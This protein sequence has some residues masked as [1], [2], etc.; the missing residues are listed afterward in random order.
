MNAERLDTGTEAPL[1]LLLASGSEVHLAGAGVVR[2]T[3]RDAALLAWLA[4]EGPT[5]R[6]RLAQLLWPQS[7]GESAGNALRQRL[8]HLKKQFGVGLVTGRATL[9][10][11][12]RVA[13]DLDAASGVLGEASH[14]LTGELAEWVDRRRLQRSLGARQKLIERL[15]AAEQEGDY[16]K[17][18]LAANEALT[19]DPMS[20]EAHQ[21]VI[22]LYYLAGDRPLALLAFDRCERVLKTEFGFAP[23]AKT[24]ELLNAI[25]QSR[26]LALTG[27]MRGGGLPAA[28]LRPPR[29][30]GRADEW[31]GLADGWGAGRSAIIVGEGGM[32]K[33]RLVRDFAL[34]RKDALIVD[35]RPGDSR[36]PHAL[37]SR[38]L[39]ALLDRQG[40]V[41]PPAGV[42]GELARLLPELGASSEAG[43][44]DEARF[45]NAV[46]ALT[47]QAQ[48]SGLA[49][50]VVD[51]LQFGDDASVAALRYL[52]AACS[53]LRWIVALR[54]V[55]LGAE[56]RALHD[57]LVAIKESRVYP[58]RPLTAAE[59]AELVETLGVPGLSGAQLGPTLARHTGG[60]PLFVLETLR[61]MFEPGSLPRGETP[62]ALAPSVLAA[63]PRAGSVTRLIEQRMSRLSNDAVRL[64]RCAAIAGGDFSAE[65]A[66]HVLGVRAIDLANP[67]AELDAAHILQGGA[68]AHD[69]IDE[70]ARQSVPAPVASQLHAEIAGFLEQRSSEPVR[71]AQHWLDAGDEVRALPSLLAA[72]Q[73]AAEAWRSA[74]ECRLLCQAARIVEVQ[75][76]SSQAFALVKRAHL[77]HLHADTGSPTHY[78]ML[79]E[80]DRLASGPLE[81]ADASLARSSVASDRM[82]AAAALTHAEVGLRVIAGISGPIADTLFVDL[83]AA[84]ANA[85]NW[86]DRPGEAART[87]EA[88]MP[89][90]EALNDVLRQAEYI[91]D[92]A[93]FLD[94][95]GELSHA[96][97]MHRK[98]LASAR[99]IGRRDMEIVV[100]INLSVSLC[101]A[102]R[103]GEALPVLQEAWRVR[104]HS[105]QMQT[106]GTGLEIS[107]ADALRGVG[108]YRASLD[109]LHRF[110]DTE[111]ALH[112][113]A[114]AT[115]GHNHL[116]LTW[117]HLGQYARAQQEIGKA[118]ALGE[119]APRAFRAKTRLLMARCALMQGRSAV[120]REEILAA[121]VLLEEVSERHAPRASLE[122]AMA[123]IAEPAAGHAAALA[124]V[125]DVSR[126]ETHGLQMAALACA[127][128]CAL[129]NGLTELAVVY[130]T[131]AL[132]LWPVNSPDDCYIGEVWLAAYESFEAAADPR[133]DD[134]LKQAS[135]WIMETARERVPEEFRESFLH[136]NPF[137]RE[138]LAA[139]ARA[140]IV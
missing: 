59:I 62:K 1:R 121:S 115:A 118:M 94:C 54:P 125:A 131:R 113:P 133:A 60:N 114:K 83:S 95:A 26:P 13:H 48:S 139:A 16:A 12:P 52:V 56:T 9:A 119:V 33:T 28:V 68:F 130:S 27:P 90:L 111:Y 77:A 34:G 116:A 29:L 25:E 23:S 140:R 38:L 31:Q 14:S 46:T 105:S 71:I 81:H 135:A 136:R 75:G 86:F 129:A 69:L 93:V 112:T 100:L 70:A 53:G 5:L 73:R 21:R 132:A 72:A 50:L 74:D 128:R 117:L 107:M 98:A 106:A 101:S 108:D 35:A 58:L 7:D 57:E 76:D 104:E 120:A 40:A 85:Q 6:Q 99:E 63:L 43:D 84:L 97:R 19:Q 92:L 122:L 87:I 124:I 20:E 110:L 2:L 80:L 127:A 55:D 79:D 123:A 61:A 51:D 24:L 41:A 82:D 4:L 42:V 18:L 64:V 65:L 88:A 138:L 36:V 126:R 11:G 22:R 17:A 103:F 91:G 32:G 78:K 134:V 30:I 8:F 44:I 67:W 49:G 37:L 3:F 66:A 15:I 137:N 109:W 89:R 45:F 96:Q 10:L 47:R 102:G 39:R